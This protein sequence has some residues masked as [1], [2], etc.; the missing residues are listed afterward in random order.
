[1]RE[2]YELFDL[3]AD[4]GEQ[5]NLYSET[6]PVGQILTQRLLDWAAGRTSNPAPAPKLSEEELELLRSLGYVR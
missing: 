4:P 6:H 1:V 3:A 2:G 5:I